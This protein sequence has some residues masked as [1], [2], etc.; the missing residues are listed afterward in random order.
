MR[1]VTTVMRTGVSGLLVFG[2]AVP[3]TASTSG[4][5]RS[6]VDDVADLKAR[7]HT[8]TAARL[9]AASTPGVPTTPI[10]DAGKLTEGSGSSAGVDTDLA[11]RPLIKGDL[12]TFDISG[13]KLG[14]SA[15]EAQRVA[16]AAHLVTSDGSRR[17]P[18]DPELHGTRQTSFKLNVTRAAAVRL[19]LPRPAGPSVVSEVV[20]YGAGDDR[21]HLHFLPMEDG[22]RLADVMLISSPKGN[23][24][25]S[26]MDA[27]TAEVRQGTRG[28]GRSRR[29][30]RQMVHPGRPPVRW[31]PVVLGEDQ[32]PRGGGVADGR[33]P[34]ADRPRQAHR[35]GRRR[36][37][38]VDGA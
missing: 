20:L 4:L 17:L 11:S 33:Q 18:F 1:V 22:P 23:T 12:R 28:E 30:V 15:A 35:G 5:L 13:F 19:N 10:G 27:V 6:V 9:I 25:Q 24:P 26:Y 34:R 2:F 38:R 37:G 7:V 29:R 32:R 8:K 3:A 16:A 14:M 36:R 31:S 21:Y